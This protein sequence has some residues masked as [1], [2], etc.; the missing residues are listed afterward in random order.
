MGYADLH[1]H[2][3]ASDGALAPAEMVEQARRAGLCALGITDHDT[4][5]G[6]AAAMVAGE[7]AGVE[8]VPGVEINT[9]YPGEDVHVLGYYPDL[10][11]QRFLDLLEELRESRRSRLDLMIEK[12]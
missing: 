6:I 4:V 7:A 8:I 12:L 5:S 10:C 2:T 9:D 11:D 3:N 1:V